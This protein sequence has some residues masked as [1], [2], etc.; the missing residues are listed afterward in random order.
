M[1]IES[2][3]GEDV[4]EYSYLGE[5]FPEPQFPGTISFQVETHCVE[6][7]VEA[8][9][10]QGSSVQFVQLSALSAVRRYHGGCGDPS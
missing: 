8:A 7:S 3:D 6:L 2:I 10:E 9:S 4:C 5:S 1:H